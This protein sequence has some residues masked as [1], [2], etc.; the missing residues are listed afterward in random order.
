[1][2]LI[3]Q[4]SCQF[5]CG[6]TLA[7]HDKLYIVLINLL[8]IEKLLNFGQ[9]LLIQLI[10]PPSFI[11]A[12]VNLGTG[13]P[14]VSLWIMICPPCLHVWQKMSGRCGQDTLDLE[15]QPSQAVSCTTSSFVA[16]IIMWS[17]WQFWIASVYG[18]LTWAIHFLL[19]W[20]E[21]T[22]KEREL[23][24]ISATT[25]AREAV[26]L[27]ESNILFLLHAMSIFVSRLFSQNISYWCKGGLNRAQASSKVSRESSTC[28]AA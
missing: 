4:D 14:V 13:E 28:K 20:S 12:S 1:M 18:A 8:C 6:M 19:L 10:V 27:K 5:R 22:Q 23:T 9:D 26:P 24:W 16:W 17:V 11:K 15:H 25:L 7:C 21:C 3:R 2:H